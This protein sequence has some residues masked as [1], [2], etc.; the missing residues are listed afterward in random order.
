MKSTSLIITLL[1]ISLGQ[2][3]IAQVRPAHETELWPKTRTLIWAHPGQDGEVSDPNQWQY[4]DG[5]PADSAPDR[6]TDIFLPAS[7]SPYTVG[8]QRTDQLRHV[9]IEK[10]GILTGA[11]R[12]EVEIWGNV[13]VK[14]GG[15]IQYISVRGDKHTFFRIDKTEYPTPEN[16][17]AVNHPSRYVNL[18]QRCS[19]HICHKFQVCKYGTASVE[20]FGKFGVS[21]EIMVQHGKMIVN[22]EFRFSGA[23]GKGAMEI[24]DGGILELQSGACVAP[25]IGNNRKCVYNFNI[26]RNGTLQA[27][28][29]ER[30]LT[31]DA[32]LLL[33]FEE[34]DKPGRSGLF[35]ALG[36]MMRVYTTDPEKARLIISSI[37]SDP[38]FCNGSGKRIGNPNQCAHGNTGITLQLAGDIQLDGVHFDYVSAGGIGLIGGKQPETW[39]HVTWGTHNASTP[40]ELFSPM[41]IDGNIYY[42]KRGDMDREYTLTTAAVS[43]MDEYMEQVDPFQI[44]TLPINSKQIE[45]ARRKNE[46]IYS[47]IAVIFNNSVD[48]TIETR[49]PGARIRYTLDGTEPTKTSPLY[50]DP[51]HLDKT[52]RI[53]AKAYKP[54]LGFSPVF[55][56]TYVI[57]QQVTQSK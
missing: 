5:R 8:G 22:D 40:T 10:N 39:S 25:F 50:Q 30:P 14:S 57:Q 55:S 29:P 52:T 23:T 21:D 36:S 37:T 35:A 7:S 12:D 31:R 44:T 13:H 38:E 17:K 45:I 4:K 33:G 51:I 46:P 18:K 1:S 42:H 56:T 34:N 16:G 47:Y 3:A 43:L 28:S 2:A 9:I 6:N 19:G 20:F 26:Y 32:K 54:G 27:G 11:H 53:M 41:S 48:V 24:Y 49:V 15:F